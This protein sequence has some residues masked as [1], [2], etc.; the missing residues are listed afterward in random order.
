MTGLAR[1][2][3][4]VALGKWAGAPF[5][6]PGGG[7]AAGGQPGD[8][9]PV[10]AEIDKSTGPTGGG[11][12]GFGRTGLGGSFIEDGGHPPEHFL[13]PLVGHLGQE[14]GDN[15]EG[16]GFSF[17]VAAAFQVVDEQGKGV[18]PEAAA[19][20]GADEGMGIGHGATLGDG[21]GPEEGELLGQ[22][23]EPDDGEFGGVLAL[24]GV[25]AAAELGQG[26]H[27]CLLG[28]PHP[29]PLSLRE[30]GDC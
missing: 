11:S 13:E 17:L 5:N 3:I 4:G 12:G 25:D 27:G 2:Q 18:E 6:A 24:Q 29:R 28:G 14:D 10:G 20:D 8:D 30:R 9:G 7:A 26:V 21:A 19:G 16:V 22:G 15:A 1:I 23:V